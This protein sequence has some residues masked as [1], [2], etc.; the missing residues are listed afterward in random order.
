MWTI[1]AVDRFNKFRW[2]LGGAWTLVVVAAMILSAGKL[3][4]AA[5]YKVEKPD[6]VG[7]DWQVRFQV[8]FLF[9]K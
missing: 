8:Q 4:L 6:Y 2:Q 7:A 5:Y 1:L 9:P 3:Q